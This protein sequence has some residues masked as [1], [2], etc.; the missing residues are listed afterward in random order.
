MTQTQNNAND[1]NSQIS[2]EKIVQ[3]N[4][5]L[6]LHVYLAWQE[7]VV[8]NTFDQTPLTLQLGTGELSPFL[9]KHLIGKLDNAKI[10]VEVENAF[11]LRN[12]ELY[13][14]ISLK[15]LKELSGNETYVEGDVISFHQQQMAGT[16][17]KY[18]GDA[19]L[20]DFNHPLSG[21]TVH[22]KAEILGIL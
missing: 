1:L 5:F 4:S 17:I 3:D 13:Q 2:A 18:E 6:T 12:D 15:T 16:F 21:K 22:F 8:L 9:E 11:G 14:W 10:D 20:F 7:H 19:A